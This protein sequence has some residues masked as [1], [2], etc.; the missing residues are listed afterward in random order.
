MT[1][2]KV[3]N[4]DVKIS[5]EKILVILESIRAIK[6]M[7]V[8][9]KVDLLKEVYPD[10]HER[11]LEDIV[12]ISR[13]DDGVISFYTS[14]KI[15]YGVLRELAQGLSPEV[16]KFLANE[17]IERKMRISQ[18]EDAKRMMK[19]KAAK[20]WDEALKRATKEILPEIT[21]PADPSR[22]GQKETKSFDDLLNDLLLSGSQWRAKVD[23]AIQMAPLNPEAGHHH[24][25]VFNKL[26]LLRH[27]LKEQF[28][29]VD[30]RVGQY[31]DA[32]TGEDPHPRTP[33]VGCPER[34]IVD[35]D[36]AAKETNH[37]YDGSGQGGREESAGAGSGAGPV[38]G[39]R[40]DGPPVPDARPGPL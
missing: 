2:K 7:T 38:G 8:P 10:F 12:Y 1:R 35:A 36:F 39:V 18:L 25:T 4:V 6:E 16:A 20:S 28:E 15:S 5:P 32:L 29:F 14:G 33:T 21:I 13:L 3:G 23:M 9:E 11:A 30:K 19:K 31:L 22:R 37:D 17:F 26:W 24:F 34:V 40:P 27:A